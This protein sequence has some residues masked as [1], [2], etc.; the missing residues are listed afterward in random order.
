MC[1]YC[2]IIVDISQKLRRHNGELYK[3]TALKEIK[4]LSVFLTILIVWHICVLHFES[5]LMIFVSTDI[6][7]QK[8]YDAH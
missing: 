8:L 7:W 2:L 4:F 3:F 6:L 1:H 5:Y